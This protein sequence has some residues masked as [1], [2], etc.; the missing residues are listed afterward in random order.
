MGGLT[1]EAP[2]ERV[3]VGRKRIISVHGK[4]LVTKGE[5]IFSEQRK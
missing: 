2:Q 5:K 3:G 1:G 4:E